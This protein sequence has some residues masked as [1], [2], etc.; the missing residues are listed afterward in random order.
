MLSNAWLIPVLPLLAFI[1][2]AFFGKRL[3]GRGSYVGIG[4]ILITFVYS[5]MILITVMGGKSLEISKDWF[6]TGQTHV[7]VGLL[8][9]PLAA[10]MLVVISTVALMVQIYS[11]G[12]MHGEK[13]FSWY[14]AALCLF[15]AAMFSLVIANNYLQLYISWEIMGLCSYLLIGFWYEKKSA[16]NAA[17]K[18][19]ITTRVGDV[20]FFIGISLLFIVTGTFSFAVA[21]EFIEVEHVAPGILTA[22]GLLIFCGAVGKSAQFPLHVW[23]PD[24]MEGP[25]PVSALI[26]AATMVAAGIYLVARSF[27]I[28]EAAHHSAFTVIAVIG[29]ITAV[30]GATIAVT[31]SDIKKVLAY[32]TI[33]QLGYMIA[34]LGVGGYVAGTFHL[35]THAF[36]KALL[37]LG[38]GSVIHGV[39]TQNIYE[40]GGL[41]K[42]MK[43]TMVTFFIAC[44]S[45]AGIFPL[46]GFWSKDEILADAFR[47][48]NYVIFGLL[49]FTAFLTA[50]YMFR[51]FF[52]V[53]T[54]EPRG[55]GHAHESPPVMSYPLMFLAVP[56]AL[57][58]LV[59]SPFMGNAF[60]KFVGLPG[61]HLPELTAETY[62]LMGVS[63][64]V[65]VSGIGLAYLI[66][67][68]RVISEEKIIEKIKFVYEAAQ[69]KYYLDE[70]YMK[71]FYTVTVVFGQFANKFDRLVVDGAVK[72]ATGAVLKAS[73]EVSTFDKKA[74]D[75][76]VNM[77]GGATVAQSSA[78][79]RFDEGVIDG[80][81]NG[82]GTFIKT[83]GRR[84][85]SIQTGNLLNYALIAFIAE[86]IALFIA[87]AI[88]WYTS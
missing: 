28:L 27:F 23:L 52:L 48:G 25:T 12:Y 78:A 64:L 81:V 7:G 84:M 79:Q 21:K 40:M 69:N 67:Y 35:M 43:I 88:A 74:I 51:L 19:F 75:G 65:A 46:S 83:T 86:V 85:R 53:F 72:G 18:A 33:S 57:A 54:G 15:T 77:V 45:I 80:T 16:S 56:A 14:Y 24:A 76:L 31:M 30:M 3:P 2:I 61:E 42:K 47:S 71:V 34:A 44:L 87:L 58:G 49:V 68:K 26:H 9:D 73:K 10:V 70:L 17:M 55:N 11:L 13:R 41:G 50:F 60:A 62:I 5:V 29:T 37:F 1:L 32:S 59:G 38:A 22:I 4:A 63:L 6:I 39:G 20:G 8:I 82:I 66:Y 36:F